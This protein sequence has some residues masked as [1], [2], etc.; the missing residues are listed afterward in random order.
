MRIRLEQ[1]DLQAS[2]RIWAGALERAEQEAAARILNC[3]LLESGRAKEAIDRRT[4]QLKL[5]LSFREIRLTGELEHVSDMGHHAYRFPLF[6]EEASGFRRA[7]TCR[8]AAELILRELCAAHAAPDAEA[9]RLRLLD[10]VD[11][12]IA[13]TA[14]FLAHAQRSMQLQELPLAA[15]EQAL[16]CGHPLHPTPKS[17]EGFDEAALQ[18]YAPELGASFRLH[19]WA[20]RKDEL[21]EDWLPG[22]EA[23]IPPDALESASLILG[24]TT[25]SYALLPVHPWQSNYLQVNHGELRAMIGERRVVPL[26]EAGPLVYPTSSVRTVWSPNQGCFLKLP[27]HVRI[28]NFIRVNTREQV[29]RTMDAA[30]ICAAVRDELETGPA[31]LLLEYGCRSV[32]RD[33]LF[34]ELAVV[35]RESP[36]MLLEQGSRWFPAASLMEREPGSGEPLL[37][38]H[39]F[40]SAPAGMHDWIARY[41]QVFLVPIL[42]VF[43]RLGISL[44]AHVQNS[45]IRLDP[46]GMPAACLIRDLEGI[47]IDRRRAAELGWIGE[48]VPADSPVLYGRE[49]AF[50]RLLYYA[51]TNHMGHVI[52]TVS[53][54]AGLEEQALWRRV[55]HVLVEAAE[56]RRD[57]APFQTVVASLLEREVLP[58]KANLTSQFFERGES[59]S[60]VTVPNLLWERGTLT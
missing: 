50:E 53:R 30:R 54:H 21:A 10:Q 26:G 25:E 39:V 36:P 19:Y 52:A 5:A 33:S 47:S 37:W 22:R 7:V 40:S 48:L 17:A 32:R 24:E 60:Y 51:V 13:H 46:E 20:V 58:A 11:N 35:F 27:L 2:D 1:E 23:S 18:A 55:R 59:P 44:E 28:T 31:Q 42:D 12:S 3:Y 56:I 45:L 43:A 41:A 8:K 34:A 49:A 4:K 14:E 38:R 6:E 29:A 15:A 9:R 16:R 57:A